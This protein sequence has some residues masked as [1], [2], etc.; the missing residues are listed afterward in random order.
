MLKKILALSVLLFSAGFAHAALITSQVGDQDCFG[1][2][3]SCAAG[4]D[5][6]DGLGGSFFTDYRDAGDLADA[7]H[8]DIWSAPNNQSWVHDYTIVGTAT[9]AFLDL[10][11]AGCCDI[12]PVDL[13]ADAV[14]IATLDFPSAFQTVQDLSIAVPLALL[15][16]STQF[17]LVNSGGDGYIIDYSI[18]RIE[19]AGQAVP[20]PATLLLLGLGLATMGFARRRAR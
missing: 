17:S 18:L 15:D 4:D 20:V 16:G 19:T 13:L 3:G 6:R 14:T 2:G 12:G 7:P 1:L 9:S 10:F 8:T 11:I 5:F